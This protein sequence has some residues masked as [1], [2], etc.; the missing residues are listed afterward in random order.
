M[1]VA[2]SLVELLDDLLEA[3]LVLIGRAAAATR[4]TRALLLPGL[5]LLR[6]LPALSAALLLA[7]LLLSLLSLLSLLLLPLLL[8]LP[9]ALEFFEFALQLQGFAAQHLLL[10]TIGKR[11]T[12]LL[13]APLGQLLLAARK[14]LQL[15]RQLV[16]L[17]VELLL[18]GASAGL[19][20]VLVEVHLQLEHLGQVELRLPAALALAIPKR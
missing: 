11:G 3:G 2:G 5:L 8:G 4:C 14:L 20:L 17:A 9:L 18:G 10:P 1:H 12:L 13:L 19:V 16:F 6:L 15:V 7:R